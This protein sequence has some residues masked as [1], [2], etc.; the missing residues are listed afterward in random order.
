MLITNNKKLS[1]FFN[2][3]EIKHQTIYYKILFYINII[4]LFKIKKTLYIFLIIYLIFNIIHI[5]IKFTTYNVV[6]LNPL[7]TNKNNIFYFL[8]ILSFINVNTLLDSKQQ[9]KLIIHSILKVLPNIILSISIILFNINIFITDIIYYKKSIINI[10]FQ[11]YDYV[12]S[13]SKKIYLNN[14]YGM[15]KINKNIYKKFDELSNQKTENV[16]TIKW[17]HSIT[18]LGDNVYHPAFVFY[19]D[20]K[21]IVV[22]SLTHNP[23]NYKTQPLILNDTSRSELV[24][25]KMSDIKTMNT[26]KIQTIAK[27]LNMETQ[28]GFDEKKKL[29]E[30]Y[31]AHTFSK[32]KEIIDQTSDNK[33]I[34][35]DKLIE[36][37]Q[38]KIIQKLTH[39]DSNLKE[40]YENIIKEEDVELNKYYL[41]LS[42]KEKLT[43]LIKIASE[44]S[45]MTNLL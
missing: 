6:K 4:I 8:S 37:S 36:M 35:T 20:Y 26:S 14:F 9:K 39:F 28:E 12:Y 7:I 34:N 30:N 44:A 38:G 31:N 16:L 41:T 25:T 40:K 3:K 43:L 11:Y 24:Y 33:F 32:S 19:D 15:K 21:N 5:Y 17:L 27:Q 23:I 45:N 42:E 13:Y 1:N 29:I 22:N 2:F 10:K 18:E